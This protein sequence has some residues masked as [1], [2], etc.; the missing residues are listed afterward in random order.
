[1]KF[2]I[3]TELD[4]LSNLNIFRTNSEA[5]FLSFVTTEELK[6]E[7]QAEIFTKHASWLVLKYCFK[8]KILFKIAINF[9]C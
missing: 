6:S 8:N 9:Y 5:V 3:F 1:M 7:I 2:Y 4:K